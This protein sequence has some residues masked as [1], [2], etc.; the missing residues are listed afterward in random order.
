MKV[1]AT[2][3]QCHAVHMQIEHRGTALSSMCFALY[4]TVKIDLHTIG[5]D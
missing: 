3:T 5:A 1:K 4:L 2:Q